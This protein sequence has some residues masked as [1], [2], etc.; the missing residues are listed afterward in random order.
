[1]KKIK[2]IRLTGEGW[3]D[4]LDQLLR[5]VRFTQDGLRDKDGE[6]VSIATP[7]LVITQSGNFKKSGGVSTKSPSVQGIVPS[8]ALRALGSLNVKLSSDYRSKVGEERRV[9]F[10]VAGVTSKALAQD[11][12]NSLLTSLA[13]GTTFAAWKK[14]ILP[15]KL[16]EWHKALVEAKGEKAAEA[17]LK[18]IFETNMKT[19]RAV[20]QWQRGQA[21]KRYLPYYVYGASSS[22]RRRPEHVS[23]YGVVLPVD[24]PF[25]D[26]YYPPSAFGCRCSVRQITK[27]EAVSRGITADKPIEY[28]TKQSKGALVTLPKGTSPGWNYNPG[29]L[30]R[31]VA[32]A[33]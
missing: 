13:N 21:T 11:V 18:L 2:R 4:R 7:E 14:E 17:R 33:N 28:V 26:V 20:G 9:A 24:D 16:G 12:R 1:M 5:E 31:Q 30:G 22:A 19:A 15:N 3:R 23:F 8:Q 29:K 6:P 32:E 10:A 25:W 27:A